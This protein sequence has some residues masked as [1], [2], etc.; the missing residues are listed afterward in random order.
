MKN[1]DL[2]ELVPDI[3]T[4]MNNS[5]GATK[6]SVHLAIPSDISRFQWKDNSLEL[7]IKSFLMEARMASRHK[8]TVHMKITEKSK[9]KGLE[10]FFAFS[11]LRWIH[12]SIVF[13]A[14]S[15]FTD[16]AKSIAGG[17][18]YQCLEWI[19]SDNSDD[20]LG[21]YCRNPK[22]NPEMILYLSH[23]ETRIQCDLLIPVVEHSKRSLNSYHAAACS[24]NA[25]CSD[26]LI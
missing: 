23:R 1:I 19:G 10:M 21:A 9:M 14:F 22:E 3:V 11:P 2:S 18:G 5:R 16:S 12:C 8:K 6:A 13:Q 26:V 4:R 25:V 15:K 17:L 20:Q 7:M 24:G